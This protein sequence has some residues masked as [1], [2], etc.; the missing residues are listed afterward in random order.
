MRCAYSTAPGLRVN[1]G[2]FGTSG[3][4]QRLSSNLADP[5]HRAVASAAGALVAVRGAWR[6]PRD[7]L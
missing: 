1:P 2:Y 6:V 7:P 5:V 4:C 3:V